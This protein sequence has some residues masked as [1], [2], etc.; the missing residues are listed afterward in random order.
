MDMRD[1][2]LAVALLQ[3]KLAE[4]LSEDALK[5][6][7]TLYTQLSAGLDALDALNLSHIE[8]AVRFVMSEGER[9]ED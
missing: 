5:E 4:P 9:N 6:L 3:D 7:T 8:P 1:R 2:E